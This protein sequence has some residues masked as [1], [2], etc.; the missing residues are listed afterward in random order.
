VSTFTRYSRRADAV[1]S[2]RN[3]FSDRL[4]ALREAAGL[5][6]A[7]AAAAS[8]VSKVS[9][10]QLERGLN[11]PTVRTLQRLAQAYGVPVSVILDGEVYA[12]RY[13]LKLIAKHE[14]PEYDESQPALSALKVAELLTRI[15]KYA[16]EMVAI[17]G[18]TE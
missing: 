18:G 9:I 4:H 2:N 16:A 17:T 5:S 12:L 14:W 13:A 6:Q 11:S 15:Q 1:R 10:G 3:A 8:G 7:E